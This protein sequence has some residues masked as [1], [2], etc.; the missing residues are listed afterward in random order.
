M[1]MQRKVTEKIVHR[2]YRH[3]NSARILLTLWLCFIGNR[4]YFR[5]RLLF[6]LDDL[7]PRNLPKPERLLG[8][9]IT[10]TTE[11]HANPYTPMNF[12]EDSIVT[13]WTSG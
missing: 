8:S 4:F 10:T 13:Q 9:K 2:N 12:N 3:I 7:S 1:I 5:L 11:K 6:L